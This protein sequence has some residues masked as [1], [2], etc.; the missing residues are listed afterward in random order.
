[1]DEET[2]ILN[3]PDL[4]VTNLVNTAQTS[5]AQQLGIDPASQ[6]FIES[7]RAAMQQPTEIGAQGMSALY[8]GLKH[9]INVGSYSGS[10]L[11]SG[12]IYVPGGDIMAIDPILAKRQKEEQARIAQAK[13]EADTTDF[14]LRTAPQMQDQF[15]Q[16]GINTSMNKLN[17][18][19][20]TKAKEIYGN[21]FNI[22]MK[23]PQMFPEGREYIAAADSLEMLVKQGNQMT[24]LLA[25]VQ[26][27]L[28]KGSKVYSPETLEA[29]N[30][31]QNM[32]DAFESG[33]PKALIG[34]RQVMV[35]LQGGKAL[36]EYFNDKKVIGSIKGKIS[37]GTSFSNLNEDYTKLTTSEKTSYDNNIKLLAQ[38]LAQNEFAS[39]LR[40][41]L[42]TVQDIENRLRGYLQNE[43]KSRSTVARTSVG[44]G[45]S[46]SGTK[47]TDLDNIDGSPNPKLI[48][49]DNYNMQGE[50]ILQTKKNGVLKTSGLT[51]VNPDGSETKLNGILEITPVSM[52]AMISSDKDVNVS[53]GAFEAGTTIQTAGQKI[54]VITAKVKTMEDELDPINQEPTGKKI[55]VEKDVVLKLDETLIKAM[56]ANNKNLGY[57]KGVIEQGAKKIVGQTEKSSNLAPSKQTTTEEVDYSNL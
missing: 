7:Q 25:D 2:N 27:N 46:G 34:L 48:N 41:G 4:G 19:F 10:I 43:A 39:E 15:F 57:E 45:S 18:E 24:T 40:K 17:N 33:D 23:N 49:N 47:L 13:M 21:D 56:E 55:Q 37:G 14:K 8:P 20:M 22:V 6:A 53:G 51:S 31:Y 3:N 50:L 30:Q 5:Q 36:D 26:S 44:D 52:N 32:M 42:Y 29:L 12:N 54:P 16:E 28:D 38:S 35:D 11:G 9:N 1:M